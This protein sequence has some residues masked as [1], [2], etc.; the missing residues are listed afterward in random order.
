MLEGIFKF[1]TLF[2]QS[3]ATLLKIVLRSHWFPQKFHKSSEDIFILG[4]G[5][6]LKNDLLKHGE[7]LKQNNL[8]CV[9]KFPDT[10]LFEEYKPANF[11]I[12]SPGFW[13]TTAEDYNV[14]VRKDII[15]VLIEKASWPINV[16][17][18]YAAKKNKSFIKKFS[19]NK[20]LTLCFYNTH[21]S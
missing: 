2:I 16:F 9:N 8:L 4:N 14:N 17:L 1:L 21:Q 12:C 5:P 3:K 7:Q 6:S 13:Y 18:P 11:L 19:A 15:R 10:D 20:H